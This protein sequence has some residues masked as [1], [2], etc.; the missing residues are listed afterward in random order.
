M[1][2]SLSVLQVII[3]R[4]EVLKTEAEEAWLQQESRLQQCI[5]LRQFQE[6]VE[7]VLSWLTNEAVLFL[8]THIDVGV[9]LEVVVR[10]LQEHTSFEQA[11]GVR[12]SRFL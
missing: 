9:R 11:A 2:L 1:V 8:A 6:S 5:L 3:E 10:L 7:G 12:E 4:L